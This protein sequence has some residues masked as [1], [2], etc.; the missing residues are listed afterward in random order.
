MGSVVFSSSYSTSN[1]GY[2]TYNVRIG[3]S[4]AYNVS[5]NTTTVRITSVELQKEGNA[6]NWGSIPFFG[7]V[8]VN[9]T[10]LLSM[11]GGSSVRVSLSGGG[12]CSV[13][14]PSSASVAV[15]HNDDGTGSVGFSLVGALSY[16]GNEY[17]G[18]LYG[19]QPFGAEEQTK[20]VA[21]TTRPRASGISS[22]SSSVATLGSFSL[23]VSRNS[24]AFCHKATI[25]IGNTAVY[26][27]G[28]FA[29]SL[30]YT[31]PR[32]WFAPYPSDST[33]SATVSVQTYSDASCTS[34]VGSPVTRSFT[35]TADEG[36]K[37]SL[38]SGW[39]SLEPCNTGAVAGMSGY[40]KGY[41]RAQA[42]FDSSKIDMSAAVGASIA[43]F[44]VVCQGA[45]S[46]ASPYLTPVLGAASVSVVCTVT[47]TRGR[48]ASESFAL[49]A[50]DYAAPALSDVEIFRCD[51]S[52]APDGDGTAFSA[53]A[54]LSFSPLGGQNSCSLSVAYKAAGG[55]Y[56]QETALTSGVAAAPVGTISADASYTVRVSAED[57]LGNSAVYYVTIPTRKWA[58][59]FRGDGSGV[60]FGKAA[61]YDDTFEISSDW[62]V[63][64]GKPLSVAS[65]GTG[66]AGAAG[67]RTN[68]G[69]RVEIL[70]EA[71]DGYNLLRVTRFLNTYRVHYARVDAVASN[72]AAYSINAAYA[73]G[74]A[75]DEF[76]FF[77]TV[78]SQ[79]R[80]GADGIITLYSADGNPTAGVY[81]FVYQK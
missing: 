49:T 69:I 1:A 24:A 37:P 30:S 77:G 45:S 5:T 19:G 12:Y 76:C 54:T 73:P 51:G 7:S 74:S 72:T 41:S 75:L 46:S 18:A 64:L 44:S 27:S 56:G 70:Q 53:K 16:A 61:E 31:V 20:T 50:A 17:F 34:A 9:G 47:D 2:A 33:L 55:S 26:T 38:S 15:G 4:E 58:M 25:S 14:I 42:S 36:M 39:A 63:L 22:C 28:A 35:V 29:A 11:N 60:A 48:T 79:A 3:Y 67:A 57:A 23:S 6:T 66:A 80:L 65:G 62:D 81:D 71:F 13:A 52:G 68:L 43:S 32:S 78:L 21:L 59:K 8:R 40:I 10:T